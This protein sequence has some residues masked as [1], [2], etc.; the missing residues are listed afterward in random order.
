MPAFR[1]VLDTNVV[2][3]A[4][5]SR[6]EVS[7]N[8]EVLARLESGGFTLLYSDGTLVEY[9]LKLIE[10]G[11]A[12]AKLLEFVV[13]VGS[14]GE[15]VQIEFFHLRRYPADVDDIAFVLCA[16]NGNAT[17]LVTYDKGFDAIAPDCSFVI[18]EALAFLAALRTAR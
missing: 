6:R 9:V 1:A 7:P 5:R 4:H 2:L 11:I 3:A 13:A 15:R 8:R 12:D 10:H 18:C 14:L 16:I 17:H